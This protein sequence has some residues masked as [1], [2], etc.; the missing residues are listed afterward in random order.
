MSNTQTE[1]K[2]STEL[3]YPQ[4]YN[5]IFLNDDFTPMPFVIHLLIEIFN[6][7]IEESEIITMQIH[8]QGKS[9]VATYSLEIAEQKMHEATIVSRHQGH[10]LQII[11]EPV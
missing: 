4:K 6:K 10:P 7:N 11:I 8:E 2:T 3:A 1:Q 5:V 9:V